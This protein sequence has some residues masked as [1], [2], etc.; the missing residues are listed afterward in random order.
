M[1]RTL[2]LEK[3][4]TLFRVN[5]IVAIL[6]PR[7]CGKTTLARSYIASVGDINKQNYFDLERFIDMDRLANPELS[8]SYLH[9]LVI[10]HKINL[11][12]YRHKQS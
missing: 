1:N 12:F 9:G 10:C 3:I 6:G 7:Q 2:F 11:N 8:L 4:I 5:P